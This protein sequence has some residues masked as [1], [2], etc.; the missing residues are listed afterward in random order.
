MERTANV[1]RP[2]TDQVPGAN[3]TLNDGPTARLHALA[4]SMGATDP[5]QAMMLAGYSATEPL[6]PYA[7]YTAQQVAVAQNEQIT[8]CAADLRSEMAATTEGLEAVSSLLNSACRK[9]VEL[10]HRGK[11]MMGIAEENM[12]KRLREAIRASEERAE[13]RLLDAI[14]ESEDRAERQLADAIRASEEKAEV[15]YDKKLEELE[16]KLGMVERWAGCLQKKVDDLEGRTGTMELTLGGM[17]EKIEALSRKCEDAISHPAAK[18]G[19]TDV[20]VDD[21]GLEKTDDEPNS[22]GGQKITAGG[23]TITMEEL[24]EGAIGT[25]FVSIPEMFL[26][27]PPDPAQSNQVQSILGP[28]ANRTMIGRVEFFERLRRVNEQ[29]NRG[30]N[31]LRNWIL[32]LRTGI[33]DVQRWVMKREN[34]R[35]GYGPNVEFSDVLCPDGSYP[36]NWEF[37]GRK[38]FPALRNAA[39]IENLSADQCAYALKRY[40]HRAEIIPENLQ[41]RKTLLL[42]ELGIVPARRQVH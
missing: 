7:S 15:R 3:R 10:E 32:H 38:L 13:R 20:W 9:I 33:I 40:G 5:F 18:I 6:G 11:G 39:T 12:E 41:A 26:P 8:K 23:T 37:N 14:R 21:L 36:G 25:I 2:D 22:E 29:T 4:T 30:M 34:S 27:P 19:P 1:S 28:G 42:R 16:S 17:E 31:G 24:E 35:L